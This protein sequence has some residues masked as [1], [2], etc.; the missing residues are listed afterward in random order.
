VTSSFLWRAVA[1]MVEQRS[2]KPVLWVSR[3]FA[4][5]PSLL[6]VTFTPHHRALVSRF[7]QDLRVAASHGPQQVSFTY[8]T[9]CAANLFE[10]WRAHHAPV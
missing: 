7:L 3:M 4:R 2:P 10:D 5:T 1:P 9:Q 6:Y 8:V